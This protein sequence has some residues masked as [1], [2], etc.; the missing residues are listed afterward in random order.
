MAS[1]FQEARDLA[2]ILDQ[3]QWPF[4]VISSQTRQNLFVK[5]QNL[6]SHVSQSVVINNATKYVSGMS[7]PAIVR[8]ISTYWA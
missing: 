4:T 2:Q 5:S 6:T 8:A 3:W 1:L 7:W